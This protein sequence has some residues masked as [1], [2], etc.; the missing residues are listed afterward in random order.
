MINGA[1]PSEVRKHLEKQQ[2]RTLEEDAYLKA[3]RGEIP[4]EEIV[5]L[6]LGFATQVNDEDAPP[7]A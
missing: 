5:K 4:P 2:F 1:A 7:Q 3:C 6:G